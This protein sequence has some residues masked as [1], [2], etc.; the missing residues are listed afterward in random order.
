V[1]QFDSLTGH[2][3]SYSSASLRPNSNK[4]NL[5]FVPLEHQAGR[6]ISGPKTTA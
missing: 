6:S 2:A 3:F 5:R 4:A 1:D